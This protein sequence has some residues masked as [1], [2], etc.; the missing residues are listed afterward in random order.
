MFRSITVEVDELRAVVGVK[1]SVGLT[2]SS[3]AFWFASFGSL[4]VVEYEPFLF[5]LV[6]FEDD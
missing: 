5:G 6:I 2:T 1:S 3:A 4:G